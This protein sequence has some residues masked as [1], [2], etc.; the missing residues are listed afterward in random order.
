MTGSPLD[1]P[2]SLPEI[3]RAACDTLAD[4]LML[5]R[6][7][8]D[9]QGRVV[10]FEWLYTNPAASRV[11]RR[12]DA[13][14]RGK[15]LLVEMPGNRESGLFERYVQVVETGEP[16]QHE[17]HYSHDG[18]DDWFSNR[19]TKVGDG[20]LVC[21]Q[22][23][24]RERRLEREQEA[25][26]QLLHRMFMQAPVAVSVVRPPDFVFELANPRYEEMVGRTGVTG[27]TLAT[28]FPELPPGEGVF[29]ILETVTRTGEPIV[30]PELCVPIDRD[31]DGVP[32][33]AYFMFTSQPIVARDGT[34]DV[35]L[36]V[37]VEVTERK[38]AE[39]ALRHADAQKDEFLAVLAHE[40]RNP[41][42]VVRS[43]HA[44]LRGAE[45]DEDAIAQVD[46]VLERQLAHMSRLLDDLLDVGRLSRGK[47]TLEPGK[48]DF[49]VVV[50]EV[51]GDH[52]AAFESRGLTFEA[53][54][55]DSPVWLE[56]DA[57]RLAQVVDNLVTNALKYTPPP[58]R[59][60]VSV[61]RGDG[62]VR[63][64]VR[65]TGVG[66][67]PSLTARIFEPF[68]Q[69]PQSIA[70]SSGGLGLGL[71]LAQRVAELHGGALSVE[72]EGVG[73]GSVF[74]LTLPVVPGEAATP[75]SPSPSPSP[76][77]TPTDAGPWR[78][79]VVE[80][81]EDAAEL[82]VM[83]LRRRG[84]SVQHVAL[85]ADAVEAVRDGEFDVVLCDI[86]LPGMD[87]YEVARAVRALPGGD[88]LRIVALSGYGQADDRRKSR[89]AGF[90]AHLLKPA[91]LD[92][93]LAAVAARG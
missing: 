38:L 48:V 35:V 62:E 11:V 6:S 90:D 33:E 22:N 83:L 43:A 12:D 50:R 31:G 36:T 34:V 59:V 60:D 25:Q 81:N 53:C 52:R 17:F 67:D 14:L 9:E 93:V 87:G 32:E 54:L 21:F 23:V 77:P 66:V 13:D 20:F 58:G 39:D 63:L 28:A 1:P 44:L 73:R 71:A 69:A 79:L 4:G 37:A 68:E 76:A 2:D 86:G 30:T 41:L 27:K 47:L 15:R 72:S 40:L 64:E 91:S 61:R 89:E 18:L 51:V 82:V 55:P 29:Q 56:G 88:R 5:F 70:R 57:V 19:S 92:A 16:D 42:A 65:D 10:D 24:T 49:G 7:V 85:G 46:A 74:T 26:R 78:F 45:A 80:D 84:H 8:R 3:L 75:P